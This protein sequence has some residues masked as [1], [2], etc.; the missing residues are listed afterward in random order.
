[1]DITEILNSLSTED[2]KQLK[3]TATELLG[4]KEQPS[5]TPE[6]PDLS[7]DLSTLLSDPRSLQKI[8][9]ITKTVSSSDDRI[10]FFSSIRPLLSE[11]RR[12]KADAAIMILQIL[13]VQDVMK[14]NEGEQ[15]K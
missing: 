8:M 4:K 2:V 13:R 7:N 15:N 11:R 14:K 3:E 1:M 12:K 9:K 6:K 5:H 10:R